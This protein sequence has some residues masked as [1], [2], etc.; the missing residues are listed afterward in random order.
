MCRY[1][2]SSAAVLLLV[3]TAFQAGCGG[4]DKPVKIQGTV[5]LDGQPLPGATV[6]F[7]P[8]K[9]TAGRIA[10][11]RTESD[12]SFRLTT[13]KTDDGALRGQYQ[14]TVV[15]AEEIPGSNV[16]G[17][18]FEMDPKAMKAYFSKGSPEGRAKDAAEAKSRKKVSTV[19]AIYADPLKT[20]LKET[21]PPDGPVKIDLRSTAR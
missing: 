11:G 12:G 15:V 3:L 1:Y 8:S 17:N 2:R 13:Y 4:A 5:T 18:P 16:G 21:V 10:A 7:L 19:P 9:D 6:T 14:V 20:P